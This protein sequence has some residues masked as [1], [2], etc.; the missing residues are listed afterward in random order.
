M[1]FKGIILVITGLF[2]TGCVSTSVKP[3][4]RSLSSTSWG[5]QM[6]SKPHPVYL[7]EK[8]QRF[9]VRAGDCGKTPDWSDCDT[10]RERSEVTSDRA[11]FIPG[12][13]YW[14][15]YLLYLPE[16]FETSKYV[17]ATLG[18]IH[19]RGGFKGTAGGFKSFPPLLQ[20]EAKGEYYT[21][22]FHML[23][24]SS[25]SIRDYCHNSR[26]S[27]IESLRGKWNRVT[28]NLKGKASAPELVIFLNGKQIAEF[29]QVLPNAPREYYLKYGIY[30]SFV[31]RNGGPM[32]T[33]IAYYD[34]V[35]VGK[36]REEV[37][38]ETQ[39]ID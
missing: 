35:K 5:Y 14:V 19:M 13:E 3:V 2:I 20:L 15:S 28:L 17:N 37:E 10:D 30:R 21:A 22:C 23:S 1:N 32:P 7:G 4:K 36:T 31:S 25:G 9:E 16:D 26:I 6:V 29:E 33:Q 39:I 38:D 24:G 11:K 12:R 34:E 27:D 8:S 18:Q